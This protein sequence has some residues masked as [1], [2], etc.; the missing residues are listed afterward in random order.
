MKTVAAG[1]SL[2]LICLGLPAGQPAH[3]QSVG[4]TATTDSPGDWGFAVAPYFFAAG[5]KGDVAVFDA[6]E[7]S[8][9]VGFDDIFDALQFAAMVTG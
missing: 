2:V 3:A 5:V 6:P 8:L 9:D 4:K 7:A 1:L